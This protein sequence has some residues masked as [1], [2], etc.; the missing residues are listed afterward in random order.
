MSVRNLNKITNQLILNYDQRFNKNYNKIVEINSSIMNKEELIIKENLELKKKEITISLLKLSIF[1]IFLFGVVLVMHALKKIDTKKLIIFT[2][3]LFVIFLI[4]ARLYAVSLF[5]GISTEDRINNMKVY[6]NNYVGDAISEELDLSCPSTCTADNPPPPNTVD[7]SGYA[8]PTLNIDPQTNVWKYGDI[9]ED[10]YTS[11]KVP[12]SDFYAN[13]MDIPY[14]R[15]TI[16]EELYNAPKPFFG[17][18]NPVST[19]Y[20]CQWLGGDTN[21]GGLP[22]P[23][24][25]TTYSTIPCEYRQNFQEVGRYICTDDPNKNSNISGICE[26]ISRSY[27]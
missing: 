15:Q 8:S 27:S 14:Y 2:I 5:T 7:I 3:I 4:V 24:S 11:S 23:E 6:M 26:N 21:N 19:Y 12:P 18:V 9:P 25:S 22:N 17:A 20:Q 1:F 16:E 10:L 13:P